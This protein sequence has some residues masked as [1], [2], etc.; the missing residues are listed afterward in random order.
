VGA[1]LVISAILYFVTAGAR[2]AS[3]AVR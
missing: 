3:P 2:K 1:V